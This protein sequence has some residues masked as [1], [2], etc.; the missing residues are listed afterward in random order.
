MESLNKLKKRDLILLIEDYEEN[1]ADLTRKL[2]RVLINSSSSVRYVILDLEEK[3]KDLIYLR[4]RINCCGE[5]AK[6][7][8]YQQELDRLM[9]IRNKV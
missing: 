5:P 9:A 6:R 2:D 4:K 1:I 7:S 3:D 8:G